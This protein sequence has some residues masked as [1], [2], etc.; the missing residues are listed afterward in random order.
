[1]TLN[2]KPIDDTQ[3]ARM[4]GEPVKVIRACIT[5]LGD[6]GIFC[7]D[8]K[9]MYS[10]RMVRKANFV[11][12]AKVHGVEGQRRKKANAATIAD[13]EIVVKVPKRTAL[14]ADT[15]VLQAVVPVPPKPA[16]PAKALPWYKSPAGWVRKGQEQSLS[17]RPGE[18]IQDFQVRLSSRIPAGMHLDEL[19]ETQK[20]MVE[21]MRPKAPGQV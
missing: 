5:E 1:L 21:A 12:Q 6:A 9:G 7:V 2:G 17:M 3:L 4:V 18:A 15:S 11:R 13:S 14:P 8:S 16:A 19:T 10:S 20:K